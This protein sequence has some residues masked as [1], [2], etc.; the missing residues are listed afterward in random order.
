MF[1]FISLSTGVF[2]GG[3]LAANTGVLSNTCYGSV[4]SSS[5]DA[6]LTKNPAGMERVTWKLVYLAK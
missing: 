1:T 3:M 5:K 2:A 6:I 4:A